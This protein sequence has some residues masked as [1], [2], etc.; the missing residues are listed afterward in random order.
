MVGKYE[1]DWS[2][3]TAFECE[4]KR[5]NSKL[6]MNRRKLSDSASNGFSTI[7]KTVAQAGTTGGNDVTWK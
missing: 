6:V 7:A 1:L 2:F 4:T 3:V 5:K